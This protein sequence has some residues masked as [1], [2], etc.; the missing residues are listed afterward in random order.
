MKAIKFEDLML[1]NSMYIIHFPLVK[2]VM[3][4]VVNNRF[5]YGRGVLPDYE[6]KL[7]LDELS[8]P[9]DSILEYTQQLIRE[10]KYIYYVEPEPEMLG[11]VEETENGFPWLWVVG[12]GVVVLLGIAVLVRKNR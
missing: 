1:P 9:N 11:L 7:T 5:P 4:T 2:T 10:G 3:D 6:V 8:S 12:G